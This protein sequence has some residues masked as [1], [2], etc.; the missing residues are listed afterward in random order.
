MRQALR[1]VVLLLILTAAGEAAAMCARGSGSTTEPA[2]GSVLPANPTVYVFLRWTGEPIHVTDLKGRRIAARI[3]LVGESPAYQVYAVRPHIR[4][5]GLRVQ[6]DASREPALFDVSPSAR[7]S[8]ELVVG[9]PSYTYD[10]WTWPPSDFTNVPVEGNAIAYRVEWRQDGALRLAYLPAAMGDFYRADNVPRRRSMLQLGFVSC[11]GSTVPD[12]AF[13]AP[14]LV[15]VIGLHADGTEQD[16]G[17]IVAHRLGVIARKPRF[18]V[19]DPRFPPEPFDE[20]V[21]F[22]G[23]E[24][25][26]SRVA[27]I[28]ALAVAAM[29]T[30]TVLI[31]ARRQR[32][33]EQQRAAVW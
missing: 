16:G 27:P 1:L 7:V 2:S 33:R 8:P 18:G 3:E 11:F 32:R 26:P 6:F 29:L 28:A 30:A 23:A 14:A 15:R 31:L 20:A 24:A 21:V 9:T 17:V 22:Q 5:G 4:R 13:H 10:D 25:E 19:Y 12:E